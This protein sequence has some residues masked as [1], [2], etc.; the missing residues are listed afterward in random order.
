MNR[1]EGTGIVD[2]G[3]DMSPVITKKTNSERNTLEFGVAQ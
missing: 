1:P 3:M 2:A